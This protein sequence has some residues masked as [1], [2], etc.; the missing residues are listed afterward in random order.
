MRN[1]PDPRPDGICC[2]C[3]GRAAVTR[4]GR[5]CKSCLSQL[6]KQLTPIPRDTSRRGSEQT[7]RTA[8]SSQV[9]SGTADLVPNPEY[10]DE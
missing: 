7:G 8:I 5:F 9:L 10:E 4:D 1:L 6:I 2:E 3:L